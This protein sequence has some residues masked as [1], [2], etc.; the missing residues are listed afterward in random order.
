M[1]L[2]YSN[3]VVQVQGAYLRSNVH[4]KSNVSAN[5]SRQIQTIWQPL[6][7]HSVFRCFLFAFVFFNLTQKTKRKCFNRRLA[8]FWCQFLIVLMDFYISMIKLIFSSFFIFKI[9][10]CQ[11]ADQPTN[12][13]DGRMG[14]RTNDR[15]NH[16]TRNQ[17]TNNTTKTKSRRKDR[18]TCWGIDGRTDWLTDFLYFC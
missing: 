4:I 13:T 9:N 11:P 17:I 3:I 8:A 16:Q 5:T 2:S 14:G 1:I 18:Q 15:V 10:K 7:A 6:R 12:Q